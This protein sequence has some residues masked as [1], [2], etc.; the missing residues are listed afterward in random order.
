MRPP[1]RALRSGYAER[2]PDADDVKFLVAEILNEHVQLEGEFVQNRPF[3]HEQL[4]E[5]TSL[6]KQYIG[7][8][9]RGEQRL[10]RTALLRLAGPLGMAPEVVAHLGRLAGVT[11]EEP[12]M[13]HDPKP[14]INAALV[15][16]RESP[17]PAVL[18]GAGRCDVA[19]VNAAGAGALPRLAEAGNMLYWLMFE[20]RSKVVLGTPGWQTL[21]E[22]FVYWFH[23]LSVGIVPRAE[24]EE[25]ITTLRAAHEFSQLWTVRR[26]ATNFPLVLPITNLKTDAIQ[27][28]V[29][30]FSTFWWSSSE[31]LK[32]SL[33]P[34]KAADGFDHPD[35]LDAGGHTAVVDKDS[36]EPGSSLPGAPLAASIC[37]RPA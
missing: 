13:L 30:T 3:T 18:L 34:I 15:E 22:V 17:H 6:S 32:M 20:P 9:L 19:Y 29:L 23:Y 24:R 1:I 33:T 11:S 14:P 2:A 4:A 25:M 31:E 26:P 10:S 7:R 35:L 28:M 5:A 36:R 8:M 27:S 16:L 12:V 21:A 37:Q